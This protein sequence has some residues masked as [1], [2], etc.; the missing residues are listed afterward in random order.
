MNVL[1]ILPNNLG[2]IIMTT[3]A[4]AGLRT[5]YPLGQ[6]TFLAEEGFEGG[7]VNNPDIDSLFLFNRKKIKDIIEKGNSI[8]ILSEFKNTFSKLKESN[9]DL[10][11]N[12]SQHEYI[13]Y[14]VTWLNGRKVVGRYFNR[15]GN[16][17]I[18]D[19][20]SRYLYAIPFARR[21]NMLHASDVYRRIAEVEG[22][23]SFNVINVTEEEL[24]KSAD[25]LEKVGIDLDGAQIVFFQPGAAFSTKRWPES[26]YVKLGKMLTKKNIQV[27]VSGAHSEREY[28]EK[29]AIEIGEGAFCTAGETSFREALVNLNFADAL[30][31]GDTAL[32]H[33]AAALNVRT[34][35]IFG[36][37]NPLETGPYGDSHFIFT[38][39]KCNEFPCF[40]NTCSHMSCMKS[41]LPEEIFL[42]MTGKEESVSE[43]N[44]YETSYTSDGDYRL[45]KVS[46]LSADLYDGQGAHLVKSILD[47]KIRPRKYSEV[48]LV[49]NRVVCDIISDMAKLLEKYLNKS[50]VKYITSF[51]ERKKDIDKV[52]GVALLWGAYLNLALNSIPLINPLE[53]IEKSIDT[54]KEIAGMLFIK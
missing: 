26:Y 3:P 4:L 50:D 47:G 1:V 36:S 43:T 16:H 9:F 31:T 7:L 6:I 24:T 51:E 32:M 53:G 2:D 37:T 42:V 45:A 34:F 8:E 54:C 17:S 19:K 49:D 29:I 38:S 33:C 30:V 40:K 39:R 13:S 52:G 20:W 10:I 11:I 15:G 22:Q 18:D 14:L 44:V 46:G 27:V 23:P 12:F 21:Y 48:L 41:I 28:A 5:K 25:Y 35:A